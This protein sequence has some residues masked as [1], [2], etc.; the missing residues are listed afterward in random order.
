M[1]RLKYEVITRTN[2]CMEIRAKLENLITE[3]QKAKLK[4]KLND[5]GE[6]NNKL[7]Q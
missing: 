7:A 2:D 6:L 4:E 5:I 1:L 3:S